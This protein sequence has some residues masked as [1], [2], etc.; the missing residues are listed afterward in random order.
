MTEDRIRPAAAPAVR[1]A[2]AGARVQ[3]ILC[4][5]VAPML[6]RLA[7][8][9]VAVV[10]AQTAATVADAW[11]VGHL[12]TV[13]LASLALVF[14]LQALMQMMSAG[15]MG[16]GISSAVAR[17]LGGGRHEDATALV[18]HAVLIALAMASLYMLLGAVLAA[19]L[20]A[21]LG[22]DGEVLGGA[23]AYARIAFGGALAIWLANTFAS[24]LRGSGNMRLPGVVLVLT[25][26]CQMALAGALTLG[27]GPFPVLG[28]RGP[29]VALVTCFGAAALVLGVHV[30]RAHAAALRVAGLGLRR[31]HF[32]EILK[33]GAV[34]CGLAFLT[35]ATVLIVTRLVAGQGAAALAGFGLGSRL[36]LM[37]VPIA[38]GVGG[39]LTAAVG[40]NFG[41]GQHARARRIAWTGGLLV[42]A[43]TAVAGIAVALF[44]ALWLDHFTADPH[45]YAF[46]T[47]YLRIVA[48][49][50]GFFGLGMALYFASQGTGNMIGP[51]IAGIARIGIAA[52]GGA[53][54][55]LWL[56]LG[57]AG[58]FACVAGGLVCFGTIIGASLFTRVWR[59]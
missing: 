8:P 44:P 9:N 57:A 21:L 59:P 5:P 28:I 12:G 23:V 49:T 54:A 17:A 31:A 3:S 35:I 7:T 13:A 45:A 10:A 36:E 6:V 24:V 51:A 47:I 37:L 1:R 33:V 32:R 34:A 38:F 55:L 15:A 46:G 52:G 58:L 4:G 40:I 14:P 43:V 18:L 41:A 30:A 27:L 48:P 29:A 39:A 25:S 50:Y 19:P 53:V 20:F 42:G 11:F 16:G 56:D 2:V 26:V 22:G